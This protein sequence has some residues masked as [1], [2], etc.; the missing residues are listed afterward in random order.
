MKKQFF[1]SFCILFTL[2]FGCNETQK[3]HNDIIQEILQT[4]VNT[5]EFDNSI[6]DGYKDSSLTI[7]LTSKFSDT[8]PIKWNNRPVK[9]LDSNFVSQYSVT[10]KIRKKELPPLELFITKIAFSSDSNVRVDFY[11]RNNGV[12]IENY[13]SKKND[14]WIVDSTKTGWN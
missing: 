4:A 14:I 8:L 12:T 9:Y 10:E 2:F 3:K 13:L 7:I 1:F 6:V 11:F 5:K